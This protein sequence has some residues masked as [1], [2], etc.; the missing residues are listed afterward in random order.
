MMHHDPCEGLGMRGCETCA[1]HVSRFTEAAL[2]AH[3]TRLRPLADP[4]RCVDWLEAPR[5]ATDSTHSTL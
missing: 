5:R 4:P 2:D 1:R 3:T